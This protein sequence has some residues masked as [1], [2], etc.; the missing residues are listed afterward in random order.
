MKASH[1]GF[2]L[3]NFYTIKGRTSKGVKGKIPQRGVKRLDEMKP[4][5]G[6][7]P[8]S[9]RQFWPGTQALWEIQKFQKS[10]ELLI[11]KAPFLQLVREILQKE[12][13]DHHIQAVAVLALHETTE[14]YLICLLED[15]NLCTIH[16]KSVTILPRDMRLARWVWGENIK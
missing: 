16:A 15:T 1:D 8:G 11:P 3:S 12:H 5:A 14:A 2:T 10:T 9:R 4:K 13:G 7:T 6:K